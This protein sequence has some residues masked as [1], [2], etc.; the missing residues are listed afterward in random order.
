MYDKSRVIAAALGE[1]GYREKATNAMLDDPAANAGSGDYT[2]YARDLYAAGYYN[3]NKNGHAWCDVFADWCFYQAY[4]E[5]G[6]RIQCQTGKLG[7]GCQYS[8]G[9][10]KEA[11]RYDNNPKPGDQVFF[12]TGGV[13]NH[14]GIVTAT[15]GDTITVVEGNAG[16]RV[17]KVVYRLPQ[18]R[19]DGYGHPFFGPEARP[20]VSASPKGGFVRRLYLQRPYMTG[21]DVKAAQRALEAAGFSVGSAGID[22]EYGPDTKAA[23]ERFQA[24]VLATGEVDR[25]TA[26]LL[27]IAEI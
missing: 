25:V 21:E 2:K 3:G 14:T 13:I 1:V 8:A 4:G 9:Y 26:I 6:Q 27:G 10:F 16:N 5:A 23:A 17:R 12:R 22:G 18:E 11:G 15:E 20:G 19:I 7:A 24:K